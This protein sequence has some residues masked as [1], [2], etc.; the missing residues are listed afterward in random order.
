MKQLTYDLIKSFDPCYDPIKY[1][2][3]DWKGT[4][5]D[6]LRN[7]DISVQDRFWCVLRK[8]CISEKVLRLFAVWCYRETL[9]FVGNPDPRS[10]ECANVSERFALG[11][12]SL[13]ELTDASASAYDASASAASASAASTS[14]YA[15]SAYAASAASA[16][17][18]STSTYAASAYAASARA[19]AYASASSAYAASARASAYASAYASARASA[20]VRIVRLEQCRKLI[21]MIEA[22]QKESAE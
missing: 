20:Y 6:V 18:A 13:A 2:P 15:A 16:S 8:E 19:S 4:V 21:E 22:E 5:L 3:L 7:E 9:K 1:I 11:K 12:A 14:T 10:V 17:A